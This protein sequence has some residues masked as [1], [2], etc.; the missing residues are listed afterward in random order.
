MSSLT[1]ER[2]MKQSLIYG[3]TLTHPLLIYPATTTFA[4]TELETNKNDGKIIYFEASLEQL[5]STQEIVIS[6][7]TENNEMKSLIRVEKEKQFKEIENKITKIQYGEKSNDVKEVQKV[8]A[9]YG[10]YTDDIDGI[11]GPLTETAI[12]NI[13]KEGLIEKEKIL[14]DLPTNEEV[15][16]NEQSIPTE[17]INNDIIATAKEYIGVPYV[18]GGASANGFDCSGFIQFVYQ[19]HDKTIPRTTRDIWNFAK[20]T[21]EPS[22]GDLLFFETYQ[23]GPSH[24]GIYLGDGNFIHAASSTGVTITNY[25]NNPYWN[26]RFIAAKSIY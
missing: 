19:S 13:K 25:Q 3:I 6:N 5:T 18:W 22:I 1:I 21:N 14:I 16:M 9:Y 2:T 10:Y 11:Y 23:A 12:S 26:K 24:L 15:I 8:L 20:E 7:P 17:N 4:Q